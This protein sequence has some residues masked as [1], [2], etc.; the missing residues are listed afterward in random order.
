MNFL[1]YTQRHCNI[2]FTGKFLNISR[3]WG[4]TT[5][6]GINLS[7]QIICPENILEYFDFLE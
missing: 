6:L 7:A 4:T 1:L 3:D 2:F 5:S